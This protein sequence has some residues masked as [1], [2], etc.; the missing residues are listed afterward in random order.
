[1]LVSCGDGEQPLSPGSTRQ[2]GAAGGWG[3][4]GGLGGRET[5]PAPCL[6][7]CGDWQG[8]GLPRVLAQERAEVRG[9]GSEGLDLLLAGG[10]LLPR[11]AERPVRLLQK[12]RSLAGA[13][14]TPGL[15]SAARRAARAQPLLDL[16]TALQSAAGTLALPWRPALERWP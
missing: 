13:E 15:C 9:W 14:A 12:G 2:R 11:A 3:T 10:Q 1:M 8:A 6:G 5:L 16:G 4:R 7:L